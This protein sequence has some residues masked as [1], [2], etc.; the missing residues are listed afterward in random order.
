[1]VGFGPHLMLDGCGCHKKKLQD[2]DLIYR[3]LDDLPARIGMT[4]IMPPY[5]FK[6][7]GVKPE[8]W[9]LSGFVLIAESH[10]SIH[11]FPEK[12]FVSVDIFSCKYFDSDLATEFLK[13]AFEMEKVEQRVLARGT[14]FPKTL[15]GAAAIVRSERR[16]IARPMAR[17][18]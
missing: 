18:A 4:K 5:V 10:I 7:S 15:A 12:S 9:G 16:R 2:L 1:M 13:K 14:E 8:N 17:T 6:Y 11:T 3:L